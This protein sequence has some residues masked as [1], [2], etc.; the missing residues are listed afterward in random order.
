MTDATLHFPTDFAWGAATASYQI[1]GAIHEDGRGES[2]WDRFSATPGKVYH[3]HTGAVACDHYHRYRDDVRLMSDLGLRAYRF[4]IAWPRIVPEG[5]GTVNSKGLDFYDRLVD[6]LLLHN[7]QPFATLYHWDLPQRLED[8][9]GWLVRETADAFVE[10]AEAVV[11]RLGDRVQNWITHNEP[12]CIGWLGYGW[13]VHAPGREG[14]DAE[15]VRAAH[16]ALLA[17]GMAVPVIRREARGAAVGITLNLAPIYPATDSDEDGAAAQNNDG[18]ANRW[19]LDPIFR[20]EYPSD[21]TDYLRYPPDG[22][23][24]DLGIIATPID[25]LGI[26]Y[27]SR[28]IVRSDPSGERPGGLPVRPEGAEIMDMNNWEVYPEGLHDLLV[29]VHRDYAPARIYITEN[30]ATFAD[31]RTA[32][33]GIADWQ[34]QRY[35]EEH[36]RAASRAIR[37]GVPLAGYFAWSLFD[38]FEWAYGY[39]KRFGIV[40]VDFET[41]ERIPKASGQ[42]Y[43]AFIGE[44]H[45]ETAA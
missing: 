29:R 1:E 8:E 36:L 39:S 25:F 3:G 22:A 4:S 26:N 31:E 10:Y 30:G 20:G 45:T 5:R 19:F 44:H 38:N 6:E 24:H 18:R 15:A 27:Y 40:Y 14:G 28:Q 7:I 42:W 17:H 16:H 37:A 43:R 23:D 9:G 35:L 32:D 33:G 11:R 34:R 2:I 41:Q 12:L 21:I 13:G